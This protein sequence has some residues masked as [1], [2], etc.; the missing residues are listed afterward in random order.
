[1]PNITGTLGKTGT[2]D[3]DKGFANSE[4]ASGAFKAGVRQD[5]KNFANSQNISSSCN[6]FSFNAS[7]SNLIY[8]SSETVTP[9][10]LT[11]KLILKY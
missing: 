4:S 7:A 2:T 8:G 9:M 5:K 3:W 10:S 6:G 11:T 1:M